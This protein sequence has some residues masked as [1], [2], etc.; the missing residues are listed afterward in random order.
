[1]KEPLGYRPEFDGLRGVAILMVIVLH[2]FSAKHRWLGGGALGVDL[3]FVLSGFLITTLLLEEWDQRGRVAVGA[4]YARRIRRLFPALVVLVV[5]TAIV[6]AASE[7]VR[8]R[9][10]VGFL[11]VRLTYF[12]NLLAAF[13][14]GVGAGFNHLWSLAQEEQ[15]YALW[16]IALVVVLRCKRS[17]RTLLAILGLHIVVVN[18]ERVRVVLEGAPWE[19]V[20]YG[21]DTHADPILFGCVAAVLVSH[22]LIRI[23]KPILL[24][25]L[26]GAATAVVLL[27]PLHPATHAIAIPV[28]AA[29]SAIILITIASGETEWVTRPLCARPLVGIG[30][31]SYSLYLWHFPLVTAFGAIGL[32]PAA[33]LAV[34]SYKFVEQP[35]RRRGSRAKAAP[36][37]RHA[38][39]AQIL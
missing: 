11:V 34:A 10:I 6:E 26:T 12:A 9:W 16:P 4:F 23:S 13:G 38:H 20:W 29:S 5:A 17:H 39:Q 36:V 14:G 18:V 35:L 19:R 32:I 8:P 1:V 3:F 28:F 22:D 15:F 30:L 27:R 24:I 7:S 2:A 31:V 25:A 33:P 37:L 21:P